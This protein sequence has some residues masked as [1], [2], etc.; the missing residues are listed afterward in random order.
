MIGLK[1]YKELEKSAVKLWEALDKIILMPRTDL[2]RSELASVDVSEARQV[3][4]YPSKHPPDVCT[5]FHPHWRGTSRSYHQIS[6]HRCGGRDPVFGCQP[7]IG[8]YQASIARN[9]ADNISSD[10]G[11][12]VEYSR[13]LFSR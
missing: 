8:F 5:E 10:N 3:T 13:S 7:S 4:L 6:I 9:D 2:A 12:L 1:A 11:R